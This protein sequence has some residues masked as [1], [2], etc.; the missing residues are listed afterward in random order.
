MS[1]RSR[2]TR[3]LGRNSGAELVR[4]AAC[5]V[6]LLVLAFA[7]TPR[8]LL[9]QEVES[10]YQLAVTQFYQAQREAAGSAEQRAARWRAVAQTFQRIDRDAPTSPRAGDALY[11]AALALR[12]AWLAGK[13]PQDAA[14]ALAAFRDF[15]AGYP[16]HKLAD[17]SLMH[18]AA[19]LELQ[20]DGKAQARDV[21]QQVVQRTPP[22]AQAPLARARLLALQRETRASAALDAGKDESEPGQS[23]AAPNPARSGQ[24]DSA[25]N[26]SAAGSALAKAGGPVRLK[27]V[28]VLSALQFT[29]VILTTD[30][31]VQPKVTSAPKGA[32]AHAAQS[33]PFL[34]D[35][36]KTQADPHLALPSFGED[37]VLRN[38]TVTA[39]K[40]HTLRLAFQVEALERYEVKT[41]ELPVE[42]KFVV[43]L[44]PQRKAQGLTG[45][46]GAEAQSPNRAESVG[47]STASAPRK[48]GRASGG[49]SVRRGP[50]TAPGGAPDRAGEAAASAVRPDSAASDAE[51]LSLKA[52]LGLK[53]RTV[54]IDPGHGGHDPG[55]MA[56]GLQ[57]K[58]LALAIALALRDQIRMQHPDIRV[59]MTRE[60]D[61]FIP[62]V[63]RP[64]LAKAFGADLF[65]SIHLNASPAERLHGVETYFLNLTSDASALAVAARENAT[66]EKKVSDLNVILLDLLRDTNILESS[67]LAQSLHTELLDALKPAHA[68]RDLGVKQAPFMVLIGAEMPSVLVEAGFVTNRA[69]SDLLKDADYLKRIANGIYAG[70]DRYIAGEDIA[71]ARPRAPLLSQV[72]APLAAAADAPARKRSALVAR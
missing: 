55:A 9:A 57:E 41:F 31:P 52:S 32:E 34:L 63:R 7:G 38:L 17:D 42:T 36:A 44:Y 27:R 33:A 19:L 5:G 37:G 30:R 67:K 23:P 20:P 8:G 6:A 24:G 45:P 56:F 72:S 29:R 65:I 13:T 26:P 18:Q 4:R 54:M 58:D 50:S 35:F 49:P 25:P 21:Y 47:S 61:R 48:G 2:R 40:G 51:R 46:A 70:L 28:Q 71:Q 1:P 16:A 69:E 68:V 22:S 12:E 14:E 64:K 53:V 3:A 59:G 43:D 62:L 39:R 11:S 66:S 60:E 15:S 10:R